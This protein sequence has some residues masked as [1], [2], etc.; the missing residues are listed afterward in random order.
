MVFFLC[1][2]CLALLLYFAIVGAFVPRYRVYIG[3]A[4]KCFIDKLKGKKCSVSFD[5]KARLALST[6]FAKRNMNKTA[7]FLYNKRNFDTTLI[8][9]IIAFSVVSTWLSILLIKFLIHS[10][11]AGKACE[12]AINQVNSSI[13]ASANISQMLNISK[14]SQIITSA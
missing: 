6:W 7:K 1:I 13:N 8:I 9:A 11:C 10:P 12:I 5:N 2:P 14:S 3:E 4:W